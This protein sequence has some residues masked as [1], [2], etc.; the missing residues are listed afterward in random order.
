MKT[1][2]RNKTLKRQRSISERYREYEQRKR[3]IAESS[4]SSSEYEQR[5]WRLCKELGL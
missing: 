5:I 2:V 1:A 4:K 3:H